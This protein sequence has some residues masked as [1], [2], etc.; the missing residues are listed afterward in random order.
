MQTKINFRDSS[1]NNLICYETV[2]INTLELLINSNVLKENF[3]NPYVTYKNEKQQ[4]IKY[5]SNIQSEMN[6]QAKVKVQYVR[7]FNIGR[8][9]PL[10]SLGL[11]SIR[12]EIR[13]T[14][15]KPF[16]T[17]ID[18]IN[19]H[20]NILEQLCNKLGIET[21]YL[22][23]YNNKRNEIIMNVMENYN[24]SKDQA[25]N[26]FIRI[27][28]LGFYEKW[29]TD[30]QINKEPTKFIKKFIEEI[31][32]I[33]D[34]IYSS[35]KDLA[36][37]LKKISDDNDDVYNEH[38][39][40]RKTKSRLMSYLLQEIECQCLEIIYD[41][42]VANDYI[43]NGDVVL[44][45][46]GIMIRTDKF[47]ISL[48]ETFSNLIKSKLDY[49]LKFVTK[50]M[51]Q[52]YKIDFLMKNQIVEFDIDNFNDKIC[53]DIVYHHNKDK[54]FYCV[55]QGWFELGQNGLW[56]SHGST[57]PPKLYEVISS[58]IMNLIPTEEIKLTTNLINL[59]SNKEL[60]EEQKKEMTE[61]IKNQLKK[62]KAIN[63]QVGISKNIKGTID[64]LKNKYSSEDIHNKLDSNINLLAFNNCLF[65]YETCTFR[66][67]KPNDFIS[68]STDYN[69]DAKFIYNLDGSIKTIIPTRNNNIKEQIETLI[70]SMFENDEDYVY[71]MKVAATSIFNNKLES[72]YILNGSGGNGKGVLCNMFYKSLGSYFKM[73]NPLFLTSKKQS[74]TSADSTLAQLKGTRMA[75]VSE[76]DSTGDD[77]T[78]N[79]G[80]LKSVSG[81]D[82]LECRDLF[83]S[84]FTY[85][86]Q[87]TLF[88]QTNI[89][90]TLPKTD[91][92]I[93][94][95]IKIINFPYKFV[96]NP[97]KPYEKPIDMTLKEK[98][99]KEFFNE[100]ILML[101]DFAISTKGKII[102][103]TKSSIK[104]KENYLAENDPVKLWFENWI[105]IKDESK[106]IKLSDLYRHYSSHSDQVTIRKNFKTF[107]QPHLKE[108]KLSITV[109]D[110]YE[111]IKNI[112][113]K[114]DVESDDE[115]NYLDV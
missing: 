40:K 8:V 39:G 63:K 25:K 104:S 89:L 77:C 51:S 69:L 6:G 58:T 85:Q 86:P 20:P 34:E 64:F 95:R 99:T 28:Y 50:E 78:F 4:L 36:K 72:V 98:F 81:G 23:D 43:E 24:V 84:V 13:H 61:F 87:F 45:N 59:K 65:D 111:V 108:N 29:A 1:L 60:S 101:I 109:K 68:K 90:P 66:P 74:S 83:K 106:P 9:N 10:Q 3:R 53:S 15:A 82:V 76:P 110:G 107:L 48:L 2:S 37:K 31:E 112:T 88:V 105:Q 56:K 114:E 47:N 55:H 14:L 71:F 35:H 32:N 102:E 91:D 80:F 100:F 41:Y 7:K 57:N 103:S 22:N 33:A 46:D 42:C 93:K 79:T 12:R 67:I 94:R 18:I 62:L 54:Y 38:E 113:L 73:C 17:D 30:N 21:S 115:P 75:M 16:Y 27:I 70:K 5:K 97:T 44:C 92:G 19:A 96:E 49:N 26:L 52:D 11:H